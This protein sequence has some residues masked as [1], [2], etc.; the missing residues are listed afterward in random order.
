MAKETLTQG[1]EGTLR[2]A[3]PGDQRDIVDV[4]NHAEGPTASP[5]HEGVAGEVPRSR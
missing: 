5:V 3:V 4:T 1:I 2:E